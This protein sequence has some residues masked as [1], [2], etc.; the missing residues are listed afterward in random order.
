MRPRFF[1]A[2]VVAVAALVLLGAT[3]GGLVLANQPAPQATPEPTATQGPTATPEPTATPVPTEPAPTAPAPTVVP[4]QAGTQPAPTV[5]PAQAGTQ[6]APTVV[7]AQAGTQGPGGAPTAPFELPPLPPKS[8][9]VVSVESRSPAPSRPVSRAEREAAAAE[10]KSQQGEV[11]TWQDGD[12]TLGA[13]LQ[14]DL[15]VLDTASIKAD[16][17]VVVKGGDTSIV[18]QRGGSGGS[19]PVFRSESGG[20]LMTLPGG[21]LLA[22][23]PQWDQAQVD[24]FFDRNGIS[25]DRVSELGFIPNGFV[26]ETEPGFP[27]LELANALADQDGVT[28]SS[29]NWW[30]EVQAK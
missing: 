25:A 24:D 8:V 3:V 27:S 11:Y 9:D 29:P 2:P 5:V 21:V 30:R 17:V 19:E 6:G 22:L 12:R 14:D 15:V 28:V 10:A 13:V 26:V 20:E 4:A 7:P 16:D 1:T 18:E 23:D